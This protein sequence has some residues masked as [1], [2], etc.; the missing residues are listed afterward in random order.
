MPLLGI[1]SGQVRTRIVLEFPTWSIPG[2][3]PHYKDEVMR[4]RREEKCRRE[5][6]RRVTNLQQDLLQQVLVTTSESSII[7]GD[8]KL[9]PL[10]FKLFL[11]LDESHF[12]LV[13]FFLLFPPH[14]SY[15]F[16][17]PLLS[18]SLSTMMEKISF[19]SL[20]NSI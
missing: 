20:C 3:I 16:L 2:K 8:T 6:E 11:S 9:E 1:P 17:S 13:F 12:T 15:F 4:E 10:T 7:D 18:P 14:S 5:R 19:I